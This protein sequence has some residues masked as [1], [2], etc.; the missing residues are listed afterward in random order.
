VLSRVHQ[1]RQGAAGLR[2]LLTIAA[3]VGVLLPS[4]GGIAGAAGRGG[5]RP[6]LTSVHLYAPFNGGQLARGVRVAKSASGHCWTSSDADARPDAW[7]C[8]VGNYIYDPCF[9]DTVTYSSYVVCPLYRPGSKVLRINLTKRLPS[10]SYS[11]T[12][13]TRHT[14]WAVKTLGGKWC[15]IITG[16]TGLIAGMRI[17]YGCTGG[18]FLL[19]NPRRSTPTWTIFYAPNAKAS[20]FTP[21]SLAS[22]WW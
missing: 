22:A 18:G 12:D 4:A 9:S 13:P 8:F 14:P 21:I 10:S 16:A 6:A 17:N 7:R 11:N 15:T 20:Q 2:L 5:S 1:H 19:G 3:I